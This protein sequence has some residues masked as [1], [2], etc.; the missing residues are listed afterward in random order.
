VHVKLAFPPHIRHD[1]YRQNKLSNDSQYGCHLSVYSIYVV[2]TYLKTF[3]NR[4]LTAMSMREHILLSKN[5]TMV[6]LFSVPISWTQYYY[7]EK[8]NKK[9]RLKSFRGLFTTPWHLLMLFLTWR[10]NST[11]DNL[12]KRCF[13]C[14]LSS[15]ITKIWKIKINVL[16]I[17]GSSFDLLRYSY[18]FKTLYIK[19]SAL[20]I[21]IKFPFQHP[22][23]HAH[24]RHKRQHYRG[25]ENSSQSYVPSSFIID[26]PGGPDSG[27]PGEW[28]APSECS[29]SCGGGVAFQTWICRDRYVL[30]TSAILCQI[31][32]TKW[33]RSPL[34][35]DVNILPNLTYK[36][37]DP[38]VFVSYK[39]DVHAAPRFQ[40][41]LPSYIF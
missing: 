9:L 5:F 37:G 21:I 29:R 14:F 23:R 33:L 19:V 15:K 4:K 38:N 2:G 12:Q 7:L 31:V 11:I 34:H 13:F 27:E 25:N 39:I 24:S 26:G 18:S 17:M 40:K 41:A 20:L 22:V 3:I 16:N 1:T 35:T 30:I 6:P 10:Q 36:G 32:K 8:I 28:S